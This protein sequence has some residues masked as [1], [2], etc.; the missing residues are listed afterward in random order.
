MTLN[1]GIIDDPV[2]DRQAAKSQANRDM[3][4]SW[5]TD[6]FS[7]ALRSACRAVGDYEFVL[8]EKSFREITLS[9]L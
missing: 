9:P 3:V 7:T 1:V 5:F 8:C 6:V 4:W 2:K